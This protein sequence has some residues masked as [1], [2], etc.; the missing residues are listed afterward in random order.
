MDLRCSGKDLIKNHL[1]MA[2]YNHAAIWEK[3]EMMPKSYFCNGYINLNGEK[4]SKSTGNFMTLRQTIEE[5]GSDATRIALADAG[6]SLDDANFEQ[7]V[8]NSA[9]LK[10]YVLEEWIKKNLVKAVPEGY[11]FNTQEELDSFDKI[12]ENEIN[13][14]LIETKSN[15]EK[16]KFRDGLKS[17]FFEFLGLKEDYLISKQSENDPTVLAKPLN[18]KLIMKYVEAQLTILNVMCPHFAQHCWSEHFI[19]AINRCQNA[20]KYHPELG[21]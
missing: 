17:G 14:A 4:M 6:D 19:P 7:K 9:I 21:K 8:A 20:P 13:F 5:Y 18:P 2:L 15:F 12:F 11:D 1:T 16:M 3:Q 10:L